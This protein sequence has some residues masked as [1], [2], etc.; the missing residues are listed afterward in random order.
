MKNGK[1]KNNILHISR[2]MDIGGA[3][4]IVYQLATDL[5]DEFDQVHV[6]STGGLW[7]E[8]LAENGIQHHRIL[9]VDSKQ[10]A[11]VLKILASLSRIIKENE[12]TLVHTHH[13]MAAFY[14]RLLQLRHPKLIHVYTAHNVFKDKL[15]LYKFA[16]GKAHAIAVGEAV[17]E[18]LK[19]DVGIKDTTVIYNGVLMEESQDTVS[20]IVRTPGVKIGCIARLSE[21]KGLTYLIE[22]MSLVTNPSVS[23]FI[24]GDG[25][26]KNDLIDQTKKLGLEERIHFLGYR[27]DV[28]ECINSF[29]FL[30][31][32]SIYEGLALSVIETFL[33]S[34]TI[35]ATDIPG[36]NEIVNE[37]NGLLVPVKNPN[38][39]AQAIDKLAGEV[40]FREKLAKKARLDYESKYSYSSF[41]NNYKQ[42][43]TKL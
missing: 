34:K 40:K 22:A 12:I 20:E 42:F 14:I 30:V 37:T 13:R 38:A 27:S 25:E 24:V 29:D 28:V 1:Q 2:T 26:L 18:N 10:P 17:S 7:E 36:I 21:Q 5:K 11:T 4:R 15:P 35:V 16:L 31:S 8:K 6:A 39:M 41:I 3:E 32:S 43:Y 9:D 33:N 23:L 19:T